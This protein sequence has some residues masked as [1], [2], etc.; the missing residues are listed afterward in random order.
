MK[1]RL[2]NLERRLARAERQV[3]LLRGGALLMLVVATA[4]VAA[5]PATTQG[6]GTT[7][8]APFA[9]LDAKGD[10]LV[11]VE[12][13]RGAPVLRLHHPSGRPIAALRVEGEAARFDLLGPDGRMR[14][15]LSVDA[16]GGLLELHNRAGRHVATLGSDPDGGILALRDASGRPAAA[17][18]V[19][20]DGGILVVRDRAGKRTGW[21]G[22]D[23][24]GG[25]FALYDRAGK[26][27]FTRPAPPAK[28]TVTPPKPSAPAKRKPGGNRR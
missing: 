10:R 8:R 28:T 5:R 22:T 17:L 18:A 9:V 12:A 20:R 11:S 16:Q 3:R 7:V 23:P 13:E 6:D 4:L 25:N 21:F 14:A 1:A 15:G 26:I 27:A 19:D 24:G 2:Q